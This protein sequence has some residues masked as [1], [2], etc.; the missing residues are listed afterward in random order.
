MDATGYSYK[1]YRTTQ[2]AWDAMY[3]SILASQ[4]SIFWEVY[5]F[6]DDIVGNK[7]LD[8]LAAKAKS[9][10]EVKMVVDAI[11]SFNL[12]RDAVARLTAAGAEVL[13]YNRLYPSFKLMSWFNRLM[14]RN[15][16][17]VLIVDEVTVFLGGVN[18]EAKSQNWDDV[19]IKI[20]GTRAA[21]PL[22]RGFAKSYI[23]AGGERKNVRRLLHPKF[24]TG[25][26][27]WKEQFGFITHSPSRRAGV[28]MR[29][30]YL[31]ALRTATKSVNFITPYYLPDRRFLAAIRAA[32]ERGV[33]VRIF[34]P[35]RLD[36]KIMEWVARASIL[37]TSKLG[38]EVYFLPRMHH[39]KALSVDDT[40]GLVGSI[41]LTPRS[42][43]LNE[44]SGVT[45]SQ[46]EMVRDLNVLF[47]SWQASA[48][49]LNATHMRPGPWWKRCREWWVH[50]IEK[51]L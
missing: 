50:R 23:S 31:R 43:S 30:M 5:V 27:I 1:F 16:R 29:Q 20:A 26:E 48:T 37:L 40:F 33:K 45:F 25:S 46:V 22:L 34:L 12:S 47:N 18:I 38:A 35:L 49:P 36:H 2:D 14:R 39:G 8:A 17:K 44:E 3:E 21:W 10:V 28:K 41:N 9:G 24:F 19:Y 32:R 42:F 6:V 11:G 7:F 13:H 15:H 51:Y 4:K